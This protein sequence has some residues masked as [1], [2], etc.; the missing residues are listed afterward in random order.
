MAM[1][2]KRT[3][4][5][6]SDFNTSAYQLSGEPEINALIASYAQNE[7][8]RT[9][10]SYALSPETSFKSVLVP[11]ALQNRLNNLGRMVGRQKYDF[12]MFRDMDFSD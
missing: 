8:Y 2:L 5:V 1:A 6:Y 10:Y 7:R 3:I 4:C 11:E 9:S 12:P